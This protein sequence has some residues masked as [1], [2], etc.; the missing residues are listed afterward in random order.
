[1]TKVRKGQA[2]GTMPR[3]AF[4]ERFN[5]SFVDPAFDAEREAIARLE[6]IAWDG[7]SNGRK[8][9]RTAKAG[10]GFADPDYDL[11]VD[12]RA[13]RDRLLEAA[14]TQRNPRTRSRV[15]VI[16]GSDRNDARYIGAMD[17]SWKAV[18]SVEL[19]GGRTSANVLRSLKQF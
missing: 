2:P 13:T 9:P 5:A 6:T 8:A 4:R 10:R 11:S 14:K 7:Y 12:W 16:V 3:K 17:R 19:P 18:H 1:M 15:L